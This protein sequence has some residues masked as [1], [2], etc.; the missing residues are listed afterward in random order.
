[1]VTFHPATLDEGDPG[2]QF[3]ALLDALDP[4]QDTFLLFTKANA[5]SNG[6]VI[7]RMIDAYA[8]AHPDKAK[9]F[10]SLGQLRYLSALKHV[11][12]VVGNSSSGILEAPSFGIATI[13]IGDRQKG[14][15]R[16]RSVLNCPPD[17]ASISQALAT[18]L[19]E[20]F[21]NG[22]AGMAN[23]YGDGKT[24]GRILSILKSRDLTHLLR[25]GFHD[26]PQGPA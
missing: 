19:S 12:A 22:L 4:L 18:A 9:A 6:R 1:M 2:T 23:P 16:P 11:D 24:T 21:R 14:R 3:Q 7:N 13:D 10:S 25:K 5:D 20:A 15:I 26:L 17:A 8:A